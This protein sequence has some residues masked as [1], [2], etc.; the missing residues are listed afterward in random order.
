M[1]RLWFALLLLY[2]Q[3]YRIHM[4]RGFMDDLE[5]EVIGEEILEG[6]FENRL[7]TLPQGFESLSLRHKSESARFR[8]FL[9]RLKSSSFY[10]III[11]AF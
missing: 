3:Q 7:D 1:V 10:D 9:F 5:G 8:I 4:P 11:M 2:K 6:G